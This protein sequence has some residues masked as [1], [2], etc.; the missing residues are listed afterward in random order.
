[1]IRMNARFLASAVLCALV[2]CT[3][4][5]EQTVEERRRDVLRYGL[6]NEMVELVQKL[7]E[8]GDTSLDGELKQAF[9]MT[10]SPAIREAILSLFADRGN[11]ELKDYCLGILA[12]PYDTK[13]STVAS[14]F[15]YVEK[16]KLA[17][18]A[19][20]ARKLLEG[21][22]AQYRDLAI[23]ALGKIGSSEDAV[24]LSEYL[25]S[26]ISGDE[27]QR[28]V[29]RQNV[30][31]ALG[32][33]KSEVVWDRMVEIAGDESENVMIRASA[34]RAIGA[35]GKSEA[36]PVLTAI[37]EEGDPVLRIAAV[38][39]LA[40]FREPEAVSL[41]ISAFRDSNYKVRLEALDAVERAKISEAVPS[42]AYRARTDP[43]EAV[44]MRAF[45]VLATV[46][47]QETLSWLSGLVRDEKASDKIRMKAVSVLGKD[48]LDLIFN[49]LESLVMQSLKDDKKTWIRYE[50]GKFLS[51]KKDGR[52]SSIA[53]AYIQHKDPVTKS[54]GMDM[55]DTNRFS[56]VRPLVEAIAANDKMG[57]LQ[58]RAKKILERE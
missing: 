39:G 25:D 48:N 13:K 45:E 14:V 54:L 12:D 56:D 28:L 2:L 50:C 40:S 46:H 43:V 10:R 31:T 53:S 20:L 27:K 49:D 5:A 11:P 6:E 33:L 8:E 44:K 7:A 23:H 55:Y 19:P 42:V 24:F 41:L 34:A 4:T 3:G 9:D 22:T 26:E 15:A 58:N 16:L 32:E 57:A 47:D 52:I 35:I 37:Y 30:M 38:N 29:I 18:A 36:I 21:E 1:M 51:K 17:E